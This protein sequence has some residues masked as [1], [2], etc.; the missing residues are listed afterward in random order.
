MRTSN[1]TPIQ[2]GMTGT[3]LGQRYRVAGRMVMSM[4]EE[5]QT[6][7]WNEFYL[8]ADNG[9]EATLVF[10]QTE[11]GPEWKLFR[12]IDP[13]RP[14][15]VAE[16]ESKQLGE[17]FEFE[18]RQLRITTVD[19][20]R[21][22]EIEGQAPEGVEQGDVAHYFNAQA[23][24]EMIVVSWTGDEVEFYRGL[25]V[26]AYALKQ[27]FGLNSLPVANLTSLDAPDLE[28]G[29]SRKWLVGVVVAALAVAA[30]PIMMNFRSSGR[31]LLPTRVKLAKPQLVVGKTGELRGA[32][33]QITGRAAVEIAHVGRRHARHE[34]ALARDG[35]FAA[36]LVQGTMKSADE[37]LLLEPFT[38]GFSLTPYEAAA[39]RLGQPLTVQEP[40]LIVT[41][42]FQ[43]RPTAT[44]GDVPIVVGAPLYGLVARGP[45]LTLVARWNERTIS[46]HRAT[47]LAAKDVLM[48]FR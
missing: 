17:S 18:G 9:A 8:V 15:G 36:L 33:Y 35:Q 3:F 44:Q 6:Y 39:A 4:E 45:D 34:Y 23:G 41:E 29:T 2:I 47:P 22:S 32:R 5:G 12:L 21:V 46:F 43:T 1:P 13:P 16:A 7:Y 25:N 26:P 31:S 42:M 27:A 40:A 30:V 38:P 28:S 24:N 20:S 37:W 14:V 48:A 19:E 10:E 11:R